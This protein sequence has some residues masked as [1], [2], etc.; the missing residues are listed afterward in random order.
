MNKESCFNKI[1]NQSFKMNLCYTLSLIP[2][3]DNKNNRNQLL[4]GFSD[5]K[6]ILSM[7]ISNIMRFFYNNEKSIHEILYEEEEL[8]EINDNYIKNLSDLFYADLLI[9]N[10]NMDIID[11]SFSFS[12]IEKINDLIKKDNNTI[13]NII[14]SKISLDLIDYYLETNRYDKYKDNNRIQLIKNYNSHIIENNIEFF[15]KFNFDYDKSNILSKNIDDIYIKII[16]SLVNSNQFKDFD[17]IYNIF[18][19]LDLESIHLTDNMLEQLKEILDISED[20]IKK[21]KIS[22]IYDLFNIEKMNFHFI[23]LKYILK[24]SFYIYQIPLLLLTRKKIIKIIKDNFDLLWSLKEN[25]DNKTN[26]KLDFIIKIMLDSEYWHNKYLN[27]IKLKELNEVLL[28]YKHFLFESKKEDINIIEKLHNKNENIVDNYLKDYQNAKKFN[29]RLPI[30][31]YLFKIENENITEKEMCKYVNDWEILEQMIKKNS[32]QKID[33]N[34]KSKIV[35]YFYNKDNK[36]ILLNI[37][38]EDEYKSFVEKNKKE[39]N[40]AN[41]DKDEE[42]ISLN[43]GESIN[44]NIFSINSGNDN[45]IIS[46]KSIQE[47]V[48]KEDSSS[49]IVQ[50]SSNI[51]SE[52]IISKSNYTINNNNNIDEDNN[53]SSQYFFNIIESDLLKILKK[54]SLLTIL[55]YSK[56]LVELKFPIIKKL[57]ND[58]YIVGGKDKK[59]IIFNHLY[60]IIGKVEVYYSVDDIEEIYS[61]SKEVR[62]IVLH[63]GHIHVY[64]ITFKEHYKNI[65]YRGEVVSERTYEKVIGLNKENYIF[66]GFNGTN[67]FKIQNFALYK[68]ISDKPNRNGIKINENIFVLI[69]TNINPISK[70]EDKLMFYNIEKQIFIQ[71]IK[72]YSFNLFKNSL[73]VIN[74]E[75]NNLNKQLLLCACKKYKCEQKNGILLVYV[76]LEKNEFLHSFYI[77]NDFEVYCFCSISIV[78]NEN[79]IREDITDK[80][81]IKKINTDYFFVGGFDENKGIGMI[82]LFKIINKE[83]AKEIQIEEI[84][85]III[86]PNKE[87]GGFE[88]AISCMIQSDMFGN[89]LI[90]CWDGHIYLMNPPNIDFYLKPEK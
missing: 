42:E 72:G 41:K 40:K 69:S 12:L 30:I 39:L 61:N 24:N 16:I 68:Y 54:S 59:I 55:D 87:F 10:N 70:S 52:R 46:F 84:Q 17:Y 31:N 6:N 34:I 29:N 63:L 76:D 37:F 9:N 85:D 18:N 32:Y 7:K 3:F 35:N 67:F 1:E 48:N 19:Q 74:I 57:S 14:I 23:L 53:N 73:Y 75:E 21:Y 2:P 66:T 26:E 43:K 77:T 50:R 47:K 13:K 44:S 64:T 51:Q 86:K 45:H 15:E 5:I 90:A 36:T 38:Q 25:K 33:K 80:N 60:E 79:S 56:T 78:N 83:K 62:F 20:Y 49:I 65:I 88:G 4:S 22:D 27:N 81:N 71:E 28:Y 11:Y 82:K 8:I 89:I 58:Y